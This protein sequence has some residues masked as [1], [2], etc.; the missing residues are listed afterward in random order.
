LT[1]KCS[2]TIL[3]SAYLL[4]QGFE[5]TLSKKQKEIVN[6]SIELIADLGIQGFTIKNLS[7]RLGVTEG[8]IYRHFESKTEILFSILKAFQDESSATL[9]SACSSV[10][11][12][13]DE[14][15][16]IFEHHFNYF[17][18]KPAVAAVI[19]SESI[20]QNNNLL[21]K[22]VYKLLE[23]HEEALMC[24]IEKGQTTGELR[25]G[26][27]SKVQLVRLIIGSIRYT[28]TKWRLTNHEFDIIAEGKVL[29][30]NIKELLETH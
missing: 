26:N 9:V 30:E 13:M 22:E 24:I 11:S 12:A 18:E 10:R 5:M 7:K 8:A 3:V 14:I 4:T 19:F 23:M 21:S 28:V 27:I 2:Y 17:S 29:L 6:I 15:A 20:F 1:S 16:F 25:N